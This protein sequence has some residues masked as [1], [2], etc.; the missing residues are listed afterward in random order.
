MNKDANGNVNEVEDGHEVED[1]D[2][3]VHVNVDNSKTANSYREKRCFDTAT[4]IQTYT[5]QEKESERVSE[6]GGRRNGRYVC[7]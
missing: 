5:E 2:E 3:D 1:E 4:T 7:S 6:K